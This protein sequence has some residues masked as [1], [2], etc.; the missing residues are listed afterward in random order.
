MNRYNAIAVTIAVFCIIYV[1]CLSAYAV[2]SI[3]SD[4]K[5]TRP[6]FA[7]GVELRVFYEVDIK[8]AKAALEVWLNH[9][10]NAVG[11][12]TT[13]HIY[14]DM[15]LLEND[16][17][18]G[19]LDVVTTSAL[20]YLELQ[21]R[22]GLEPIL[23]NVKA[24]K[25][26]HKKLIAVRNDLPYSEIKD[27]KNVRLAIKN[28]DDIGFLYL[29]TLLLENKLREVDT[30]FSV[31]NKK[32]KGSQAVL[33]VFF[34]QADVCVCDDYLFAN[35]VELNPQIGK[36]LKIISSSSELAHSVCFTISDYDEARKK[37]IK[38]AAISGM[39]L[40]AGEQ[41]LLLFQS[42]SIIPMNES[43]LT[44]IKSLLNKYKMLTNK[45]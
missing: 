1:C 32:R 17:R 20:A 14:N 40:P 42:D 10:G 12:G 31:T 22:F 9:L 41:I 2:D 27:L 44:T 7:F 39:K 19:V 34:G 43:D 5:D 16:L 26:T 36:R 23:C 37:S 28:D 35:M 6:R 11:F 15:S 18:N 3:Q 45:K 21:K 25:L 38:N 33:A 29:N 8:D 24:G 30:F 13:A 4:I